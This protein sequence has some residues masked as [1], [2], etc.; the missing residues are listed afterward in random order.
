MALLHAVT[1]SPI[2]AARPTGESMR[3]ATASAAIYWPQRLDAYPYAIHH[4][5]STDHRCAQVKGS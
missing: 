1:F 4:P 5:N 3:S 2:H